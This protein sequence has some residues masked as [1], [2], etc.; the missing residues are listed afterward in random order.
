VLDGITTWMQTNGEA[1]YDTRPW[2]I[3]GEGPNSVKAGSFQGESVSK[4][5]E[6]DIRFT[7]NKA[8]T[9]IYVLVLGWPTEPFAVQSLGLS[10]AIRPGRIGK[11]ELLGTDQRVNWKQQTDALR[12]ELPTLYRPALDYA[13]VL[14][15]TLA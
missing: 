14:K 10:T 12:V 1:I 2:K 15:V 9:V 5:G 6:K 7:R 8:N 11:L 3:Y 13:A 4:L